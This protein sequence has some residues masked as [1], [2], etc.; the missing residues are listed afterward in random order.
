MDDPERTG[1]GQLQRMDQ[2]HL[3]AEVEAFCDNLKRSVLRAMDRGAMVNFR[4][5]HRWADKELFHAPVCAGHRFVIDIPFV[6][7]VA[8]ACVVVEAD[9]G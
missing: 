5:R 9:H 6:P 4:L 3:R 1:V 7:D 8:D 2:A